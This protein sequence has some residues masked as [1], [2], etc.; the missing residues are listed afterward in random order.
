MYKNV[1]IYQKQDINSSTSYT[2]V[3]SASLRRL[4]LTKFKSQI[5]SWKVSKKPKYNSLRNKCLV[6]DIYVTVNGFLHTTNLVYH[7]CSYLVQ[8]FDEVSFP[9]YP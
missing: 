1:N 5:E 6:F 9:S 8:V 4:K 2:S 7:P 3:S